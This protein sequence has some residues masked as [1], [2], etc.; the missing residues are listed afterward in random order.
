MHCRRARGVA[1]GPVHLRRTA[2]GGAGR[3]RLRQ[4]ARLHRWTRARGRAALLGGCCEIDIGK[5]PRRHLQLTGQK[6]SRLHCKLLRLDFGPSRGSVQDNQ[7]TNGLFL[8]GQRVTAAVELR[9]GD[10]LQVGEYTLRYADRRCPRHCPP[11]APM[12]AI[13]VGGMPCPSCDQPLFEGAMICTDCGIYVHSGRPLITARGVDQD[14]V[15]EVAREAIWLPSFLMLM[16]FVP[17]R[18]RS[19]RHAQARSDVDHP[20]TDGVVQPGVFPPELYAR[21]RIAGGPE[22]AGVERRQGD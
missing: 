15:D 9:D 2:G 17:R 6:V 1:R 12:K 21:G 4:P 7:S 5:L 20:G 13:P 11:P 18:V 8:N 19:V 22:H 3:G 10:V 16:G 14:R